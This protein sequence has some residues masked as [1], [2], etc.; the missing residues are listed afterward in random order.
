MEGEDE[1]E[2]WVV[3]GIVG[4]RVV[5]VS[6]VLDYRT[7]KQITEQDEGKWECIP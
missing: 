5:Q 6:A 4:H 2:E 3:E 7:Q 1:D